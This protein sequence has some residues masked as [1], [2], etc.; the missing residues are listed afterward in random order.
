MDDKIYVAFICHGNI[1]RSPM[2]RF[3]FEN[4]LKKNHLEDY[5]VIDSMATSREEIGNKIYPYA[6]D[7]L[8]KHNITGFENHRAKQFTKEDYEKFDYILVMDNNNLYNLRWIIGEDKDKKVY[9]LLD[10]TKNKGDIEDP[11]YTGNFY[12]VYKEIDTGCNSLLEFLKEKHNI[13]GK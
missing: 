12:K 5:F 8:Q 1:C 2:A 3:I 13:G 6:K 9:K 10:F 11:W 4:L 7:E